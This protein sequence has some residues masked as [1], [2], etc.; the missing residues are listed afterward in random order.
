MVTG[1]VVVTTVTEVAARL[2]AMTRLARRCLL[3]VLLCPLSA[4]ATEAA[5]G[6]PPGVGS[7]GING[8][9]HRGKP[10]VVLVSM[11]GFRWDYLDRFSAPNLRRLA[12][13]GARAERLLPQWPSVTFPNHYSLVTGLHPARHGLVGNSFPDGERWYR[14]SDR[15]AV[16]DGSFYGG[17]PIWV[18]AENQGMVTASCFWVGSEAPVRGVRPTYWW[19]YS[20]QVDGDDRVT[21]ALSWLSMPPDR[22]PHLVTL[23][24]EDMDDSGH[25][26][27]VGSPQF[28]SALKRVDGWI[29]ELARGIDA[30][31][32]SDSVYLVLVS[33]H[34][35]RDYL[36]A[37]PFILEEHAPLEGLSLVDHGSVVMAWQETRDPESAEAL[38]DVVN[39]R[40]RHGRAWT[41][42]S[43]P[44]SW[45][46]RDNPRQPDLV[47]QAEP[48]YEV[49]SR[50]ERAGRRKPGDHGWAPSDP[51][52]HG[53][54]IIAG[55]G[56][57]PGTRLGAVSNLDLQ[58]LLLSLLELEPPDLEDGPVDGDP[59]SLRRALGLP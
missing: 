5:P 33:D 20:G 22:R 3:L 28:L 51:A 19:T 59:R 32:H 10:H 4:L 50:A 39:A 6:N 1:G 45:R 56:I 41:R 13:S 2:P 9:Q 44:A 53:L 38:A 17:E 26:H 47:F 35:M 29:G 30:L 16:G 34:G 21:E 42:D 24:F 18:T 52:M 27:G 57:T 23:Y 7:G 14:L 49:L 40:W 11:D 37:P 54:L 46:L 55:P 48:G 15:G 25:D 8:D 36:D 31:P 43:A 58:P 12:A